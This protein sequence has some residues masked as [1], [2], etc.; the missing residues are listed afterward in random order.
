M[1]LVT[2][3]LGLRG[4]GNSMHSFCQDSRFMFIYTIFISYCPDSS[5]SPS[6]TI[7]WMVQRKRVLERLSKPLLPGGKLWEVKT[8]LYFA[9]CNF[10]TD[11]FMN[12]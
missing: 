12:L 11:Y 4:A 5:G 6:S 7:L 1:L 10:G 3:Y 9:P 2:E 8:S